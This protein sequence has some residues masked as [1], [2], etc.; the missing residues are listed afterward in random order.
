MAEVTLALLLLQMQMI[1]TGSDRPCNLSFWT[2]PSSSGAQVERMQIQ[3][4]GRVKIGDDTDYSAST[5]SKLAVELMGTAG[6]ILEIADQT[7]GDFL[8]SVKNSGGGATDYGGYIFTGRRDAD[9]DIKATL[10]EPSGIINFPD[11]TPAA[12]GNRQQ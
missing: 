6:T 5:G 2:T 11:D 9:N 4:D 7:G 8:E 10:I 3:S 12:L 1:W